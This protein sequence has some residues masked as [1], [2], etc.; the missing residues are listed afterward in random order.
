MRTWAWPACAA[1][2]AALAMLALSIGITRHALNVAA[3]NAAARYAAGA[4]PW[5]WRLRTPDD[6]IAGRAF[7]QAS[8]SANAGDL[9]ATSDDGTRYAIGLPM[10]RPVDLQRFPRLQLSATSINGFHLKFALAQ[11]LGGD[12]LVSSGVT[13]S[14]G[15][16]GVAVNLTSLTWHDQSGTSVKPERLAML[17][18]RIKQAAG[19]TLGLHDAALLPP[20][21]VA[22]DVTPPPDMIAPRTPFNLRAALERLAQHT[23][24]KAVPVVVLSDRSTAESM[25]QQRDQIH[26]W[27][28][29]AIVAAS[30]SW[31]DNHAAA[32][33]L[34]AWM[35]WL[36][37]FVYAA[38]LLALLI[39]PPRHSNWR[40][41]CEIAACAAPPLAWAIGLRGASTETTAWAAAVILALVFACVLAW[42]QRDHAWHWIA[43]DWRAWA[44]PAVALIGAVALLL[45]WHAPPH[46]PT[47]HRLLTYLLWALL[48]QLMMLVVIAPRLRKLAGAHAWALVGTAL[49]FALM[50]TPNGWL[51]QL[52]FVAELWWA[53][54]FLRRPVLVPVAVAHAVAALL[55]A[56]AVG[57]LPLRSLQVG[58][59]FVR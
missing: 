57:T 23:S 54:C 29:A 18:M 27:L 25:L 9:T 53:W 15:T 46:L 10:A 4:T 20:S 28:P 8:L 56:G 43:A 3:G 1:V 38:L 42:R 26:A 37:L 51:M 47:A 13:V 58:A 52:T 17:R 39:R 5:Y 45:V 32:A 40:G 2:L 44:W 6:V 49:L 35:V 22:M 41:I 59:L 7:G 34:P 14:G 30:A 12:L 33:V 11:H 19:S 36:G 48:Q 55:L 21:G 50:H 31:R 16:R 24:S